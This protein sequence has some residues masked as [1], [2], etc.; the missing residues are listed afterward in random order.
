MENESKNKY[1]AAQ[2]YLGYQYQSRYALYHLL[3]SEEGNE[4]FVEGADDFEVSQ[5]GE[6][7]LVS[8]KHKAEGDR[9]TNLSLDFWKSVNI[10]LD[11]YKSFGKASSSL[12]FFLFSTS[13]VSDDSFLIKLTGSKSN[14][15]E[16]VN[17]ADAALISTNQQLLIAIKSKYDQL[18]NLEK[19]DFLFRITIFDNSIRIEDIAET[20]Q[21]TWFRSIYVQYRKPVYE[22]LLG[23]WEEQVLGQ[24]TGKRVSPISGLEVSDKLSS[25]A[26]EINEE[27]L[28]IDFMDAVP[29]SSEF[30]EFKKMLFVKQL[31]ELSVSSKS[32]RNAILDYYRAFEQRC[33][34]VHRDFLMYEE[35]ITRW[36]KRLE[37]EWSRYKE[38]V[39]YGVPDDASEQQLKNAGHA[40]YQWAQVESDFLKIRDKVTEPYVRRGN[41]HLLANESPVPRI[42]WHPLF[43]E[44]L[45]KILEG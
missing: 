25:I 8:L 15:K 31:Q 13:T 10:W 7:T 34:W 33:V 16:I 19:Q 35:E 18:T 40:I 9:L 20:I 6:K 38:C 22:R 28:P 11:A 42:Y 14:D 17:L 37:D 5:N 2:Q 4:L 3:K 41:F 36:E 32:I 39:M 12:V 24:L 23:W 26:S 44:R 1:S 21:K 43:L 45:E 29:S 30:E 27:C